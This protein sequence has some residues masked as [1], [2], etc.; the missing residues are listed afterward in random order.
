MTELIKKTMKLFPSL[1]LM[2][3]VACNGDNDNPSEDTGM[4][5]GTVYG[6]GVSQS[7]SDGSTPVDTGQ[8]TVYVVVSVDPSSDCPVSIPNSTNTGSTTTSVASGN[9]M[10]KMYRTE[11]NGA[12]LT[13]N[14]Q[15]ETAGDCKYFIDIGRITSGTS[16]I[17]G[18]VSGSCKAGA[19][20][21]SQANAVLDVVRGNYFLT[22]HSKGDCGVKAEVVTNRGRS[23]I[24][25]MD[26]VSGLIMRNVP[27]NDDIDR[28]E[29]SCVAANNTTGC[30]FTYRLVKQ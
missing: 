24:R 20:G 17:N 26:N 11:A 15:G 7:C 12:T 9:S 8:G 3:L 18:T 2:L 23:T 29:I 25:G 4:P 28:I 13:V 6:S 14:C 22:V 10:I 27:I 19:G 30:E 21:I 5:Q 1:A 16:T